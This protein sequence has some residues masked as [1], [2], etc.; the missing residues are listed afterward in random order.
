MASD[1]VSLFEIGSAALSL[2]SSGVAS[3]L[4]LGS[5]ALSLLWLAG[6]G[7]PCISGAD[8]LERF[9]SAAGLATVLLDADAAERAAMIHALGNGIRRHMER[10]LGP[11]LLSELRAAH[12]ELTDGIAAA[13]CEGDDRDDRDGPFREGRRLMRTLMQ[14]N[15]HEMQPLFNEARRHW[16]RGVCDAVYDSLD[17]RRFVRDAC[18][19][20]GVSH[21]RSLD[22]RG[23]IGEARQAH[24]RLER[25]RVLRHQVGAVA[26][27]R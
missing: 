14:T 3:V 15:G 26:V 24:A 20:A 5:G 2:P 18:Y 4:S 10:S 7:T 1:T 19:R 21:A 23:G 12:F 9:E 13:F 27:K 11:N 25:E 8:P 22:R 16:D 17:P 6:R